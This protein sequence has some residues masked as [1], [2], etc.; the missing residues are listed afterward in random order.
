MHPTALRDR[1]LIAFMLSASLAS[2]IG[3]LPFNLLPVMLGSM[4]DSFGLDARAAGL[5]GSVCFAGYLVGTLGAPLWMNRLNW[6]V[7]TV[8]STAGTALFFALSVGVSSVSVLYGM[9]AL[10]GFFASTMTCLGMRILSD[11]PNKVRAFGVRQGVEL[12]V[13]A[14]V[15]FAL[16]PLVIAHFKYPGAALALAGVVALLGLSALW[17]PHGPPSAGAAAVQGAPVAATGHRALPAA[18]WR[19]LALFFL[20]LVGNI[21]LWAFLERIGASL[22]VSPTEMGIVFALLKLLGGVAAFSVAALGERLSPLR[23]ALLV[24]TVI[25]AGLALLASAS[26]TGFVGFALGAWVWE[27]AFTCGCVFQTAAIARSDPSGRAVTLV[28]GAFALSSMAGPGLAGQIVAGGSFGGLLVF[29]LASSV[30]PV[31][32]VWLWRPL[33]TADA[34]VAK[35]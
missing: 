35:P 5:M 10:I 20:F 16:P 14:L 29:A 31:L 4:A 11:L 3:G 26:T 9:W 8:V 32:A 34:H 22:K 30:V 28:P 7:L 33:A 6:R 19:A 24:L 1:T 12:S 2:T 15:L 27:F 18:S 13:T 21:G 25:G 23:A 17:V